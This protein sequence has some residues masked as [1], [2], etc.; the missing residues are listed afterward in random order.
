MKRGLRSAVIWLLGMLLSVLPPAISTLLYFPL[1]QY[2][3]AAYIISG[4]VVLLLS[5]SAI[6][7]IR[8][9]RDWLRSPSAYVIW[10]LVFLMFF[11]LSLVA[12]QMCVIS[13]AGFIGNLLGAICFRIARRGTRE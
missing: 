12:E 11:S 6:P 5:V 8:A 9:L 7:L 4:G 13:F 2:K 3:G 1:W 10:L